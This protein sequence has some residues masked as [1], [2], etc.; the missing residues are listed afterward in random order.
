MPRVF[1]S[2]FDFEDRLAQPGG[3]LS[4]VGRRRNSE[5]GFAWQ[6]IAGPE[7]VIVVDQVP[8]KD[9]GGGSPFAPSVRFVRD[10][11]EAA[12]GVATPWGWDPVVVREAE[13]AGLIVECPPLEMVR[14]A[15]GRRFSFGCETEW[16]CGLDGSA[17]CSTVDSAATAAARLSRWVI[18]AEFGAAG[19]EQLRGEAQPDRAGVRWIENRLR[20]DGIVFVEPLVR[21]QVEIGI[22]WEIPNSPAA[23]PKLVGIAA[24]DTDE[25]G[26]FRGSLVSSDGP[27]EEWVEAIE[28]SRRAAAKL[29]SLGYFGPL[30]IDAMQ[31]L[32]YA[33]QSRWRPL[34]DI[35]ARW[36]MGRLALGL[37]ARLTPGG[38][39]SLRQGTAP[40]D[41]RRATRLSPD[42]LDGQAVRTQF[43]VEWQPDATTSER[44]RSG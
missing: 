8:S 14:Q 20:R 21:R 32:D 36:T 19:R 1:L 26:R 13:R 12:G 5:L 33:G 40:P 18:K 2:N 23:E 4:K 22:Q 29:Q 35:N 15:N 31:Y 28:V 10:A 3:S 42:V 16:Q 37:K 7:D 24:L 39:A 34:Q 6:V 43:W 25:S 38:A 9:G 17:A 41:S 30:G 27:G 44:S 11:K